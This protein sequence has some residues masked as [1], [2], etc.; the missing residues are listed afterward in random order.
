VE[1]GGDEGDGERMGVGF[2][3]G[4]DNKRLLRYVRLCS[5]GGSVVRS[6]DAFVHWVIRILTCS[7]MGKESKQ[8]KHGSHKGYLV[9][10]ARA[11]GEGGY[12]IWAFYSTLT[13]PYLTVCVHP[14]LFFRLGWHSLAWRS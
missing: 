12:W 11:P 6:F 8:G 9:S 1:E 5:L 10:H 2:L 13:L 14:V 4:A 3:G 7:I